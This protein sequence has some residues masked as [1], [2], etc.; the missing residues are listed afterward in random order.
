MM[1]TT[2]PTP[3]LPSAVTTQLSF[4]AN[5]ELGLQW[6]LFGASLLLL[7][8]L[9]PT[10]LTRGRSTTAL[11]RGTRPPRGQP[12]NCFG[13]NPTVAAVRSTMTSTL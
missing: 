1:P 4:A 8:L 9:L 10:L 3:S 2:S 7:S 13:A 6:R 12:G 11:V 5:V